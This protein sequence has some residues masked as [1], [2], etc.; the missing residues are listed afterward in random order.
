[1]TLLGQHDVRRLQISVDDLVLV[2]LLERLG[3]LGADQDHFAQ[4]ER[5]ALDTH[6]KRLA[7][8]VLHRDTRSA[9]GFGDLV[10]LADERM[11]ERCRRTRLPL[12]SVARL[13][14]MLQ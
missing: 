9:V 8:D 3:D 2:R 6:L 1:M 10:D 5:L 13:R 11:V 12:E 7:D 4:P 14:V